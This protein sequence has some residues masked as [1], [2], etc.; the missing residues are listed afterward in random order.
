MCLIKYSVIHK[1]LIYIC[2]TILCLIGPHN[3]A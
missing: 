2:A 3:K 1:E